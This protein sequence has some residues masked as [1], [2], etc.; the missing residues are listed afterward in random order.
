MI[1]VYSTYS[2]KEITYCKGVEIVDLYNVCEVSSSARSASALH[3]SVHFSGVFTFFSLHPCIVLPS[4]HLSCCSAS[5]ISPAA[6]VFFLSTPGSGACKPHRALKKSLSLFGDVRPNI[7]LK[8]SLCAAK[9]NKD[10]VALLNL[11]HYKSTKSYQEFFGHV[12]K[13]QVPFQ[14]DIRSK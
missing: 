11:S 9:M 8:T 14:Q 3:F 12:T 13:M 5:H 1:H 2:K 10:T 6:I 4:S 7:A